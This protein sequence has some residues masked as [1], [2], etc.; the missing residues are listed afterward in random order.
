MPFGAG[1]PVSDPV[2]NPNLIM[3]TPDYLSPEQARN[4]HA[5]DHRSDIYSLGCTLYFLLTG[6]APFSHAASLIDK[7]LAHTEETPPLLREV[8]PEVP[9]GLA[10]V[11]AKMLAK[12]PDDRY[13]AAG[14]VAAAL[15]P[16]TRAD[17][18]EVVEAVMIAPPAAVQ[19]VAPTAFDTAPVPDGPTVLEEDRPRK[20]RKAKKARALPCRKKMWAKVAAVAVFGLPAV[21]VIAVSRGKKDTDNNAKPPDG[22]PDPKGK[23]WPVPPG[24]SEGEDLKVLYVGRVPDCTGWITDQRRSDW[25]VAAVKVTT[26]WQGGRHLFPH[27][28]NPTLRL[29][30]R[31]FTADTDSR[32]SPRSCSAERTRRVR[33]G[34]R[35]ASQAARQ[36][37][38]K[39]REKQKVLAAI[40]L[41]E[42]VLAEHGAL[43]GKEVAHNSTVAQKYPRMKEFTLKYSKSVVTDG[44]V[45]TASGPED[46]VLFAEALLKAIGAE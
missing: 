39:A 33:V 30:R 32:R 10:A 20:S 21:V 5:V 12:N 3:G 36:V 2:T 35:S 16:F 7:L 13:A 31:K 23:Q 41:G 38:G 25:K 45:V 22:L 17:L 4:S 43:D 6:K 15:A 1:K 42:V 24:G 40:C 29:S 37:I 19:V 46:A 27:E 11:L 34:S 14:E 44:K 28:K 8:R 9:D 18:P 26:V